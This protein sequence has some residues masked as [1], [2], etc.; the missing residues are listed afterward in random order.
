M[1]NDAVWGKSWF[2]WSLHTTV[3]QTCQTCTCLLW[4][5]F[6]CEGALWWTNCEMSEKSSGLCGPNTASC[7]ELFIRLDWTRLTLS[8]EKLK[9]FKSW[10][11]INRITCRSF[12]MLLEWHL[13][14]M[15]ASWLWLTGNTARLVVWATGRHWSLGCPY[16]CPW[17]SPPLRRRPW[18]VGAE[19][20]AA[21]PV[22][23]RSR[24]SI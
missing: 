19:G 20:T 4:G 10:Y 11:F 17:F 22:G 5:G 24:Y 3:V 7:A 13:K 23:R 9:V 14:H 1:K 16:L 15:S 8:D 12:M 18:S 21:A 2:Y 6:W